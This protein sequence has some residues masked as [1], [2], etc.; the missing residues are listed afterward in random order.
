[1]SARRRRP[2]ARSESSQPLKQPATYYRGQSAASSRSWRRI[3]RIAVLITLIGAIGA[4][5][6][7]T[8]TDSV[9]VQGVQDR[10][11]QA[12]IADEI[13]SQY[14]FLWQ[15]YIEPA[16]PELQLPVEVAG[17]SL[18]PQWRSRQ[19]VAEARLYRPQL[20]WKSREEVYTIDKRGIVLEQHAEVPQEVSHA[21]VVDA[22][23]LEVII[24]EQIVPERFVAF[25]QTVAGSDLK[26]A[27]FHIQETTRELHARLGAGYDVRFDTQKSAQ[28]QLENARRVQQVAQNEGEQIRDYIDVRVPYRAYYR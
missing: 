5:L 25:T 24:G 15:V 10:E 28:V 9:T 14:Q 27:H 12:A 16:E 22:S 1:M 6:Y 17:I 4:I 26:I 20:A 11:A 21:Q 13:S 23:N 19:L 18:R 3:I 7:V 2:A 8:R